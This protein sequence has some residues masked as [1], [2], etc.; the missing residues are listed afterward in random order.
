[1]SFQ[2]GW[3]KQRTWAGC[4]F[5]RHTLLFEQPCSATRLQTL[6]RSGA[7]EKRIAGEEFI[8][9]IL[10][11]FLAPKV[12]APAAMFEPFSTTWIF[13][14][15]VQGDV[16]GNNDF[17]HV[18]F[19]SSVFNMLLALPTRS[20]CPGIPLCAWGPMPAGK[21]LFARPTPTH[22]PGL[23]LPA[24]PAREA[25]PPRGCGRHTPPAPPELRAD[26]VPDARFPD[27]LWPARAVRSRSPT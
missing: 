19:L 20:N 21:T 8:E 11:L 22:E 5:S 27:L 15:A 25:R 26:G 13:D 16:L 7:Q 4:S 18:I 2:R 9:F 24:I 14:N 12:K 17:S 23:P 1:M 6:H 10:L 3:L